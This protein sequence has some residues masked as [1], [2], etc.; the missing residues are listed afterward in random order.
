MSAIWKGK[1]GIVMIADEPF[2]DAETGVRGF[3]RTWA[4]SK[5]AIFGFATDLEADN[6]SYRTSNNGPVYILTSR[7]IGN[8]PALE[9]LDR[10]EIS[11]ESQDKSIFEH[12]DVIDAAATFDA[13][14]T[15]GQET[16]REKADRYTR[17]KYTTTG[18]VL[19][20]V[21][22]HLRNGVT[23]FQFDSIVLRRFRKIDLT[24]AYGVGKFGLNDGGYIYT[25]N[26]LNLPGD[27]AFSLPS[28]PAAGTDYAW[29]WKR[30]GQRVEIVGN[31][32]EQTVELAFAP[33][34]LLLYTQS[35]ADLSW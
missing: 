23:G 1:Q 7:V 32:A 22:R 8:E 33:W 25:T 20:E 19:D 3:D 34:S 6:F 15:V 11:T 28:T 2:F 10:Y 16:F 24:Y 21:V 18:S 35:G 31:Y 17:E 27:V 29:G 14:L 5:A 30:R 4:G 13:A 9:D 26:Q 12:P